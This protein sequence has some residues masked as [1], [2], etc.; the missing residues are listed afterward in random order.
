MEGPREGATPQELEPLDQFALAAAGVTMPPSDWTWDD[1]AGIAQMLTKGPVKRFYG[2]QI[3][4]S[5]AVDEM[6]RQLGAALKH[7]RAVAPK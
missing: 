3:A 1:P 4:V 5:D 2:G 6:K 7:A